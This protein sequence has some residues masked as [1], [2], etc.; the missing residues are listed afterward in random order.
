MTPFSWQ[1]KQCLF[2]GSWAT[3]RSILTI[4][5]SSCFFRT[6]A[7]SLSDILIYFYNS[8]FFLILNSSARSIKIFRSSA[9]NF[10]LL[11][12]ASNFLNSTEKT[13]FRVFSV[14]LFVVVWYSFLG[15]WLYLST[16]C[17]TIFFCVINFLLFF[18]RSLFRFIDRLRIDCS[19][20]KW[21][22]LQSTIINLRIKLL[23]FLSGCGWD[24]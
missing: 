13:L 8:V 19:Y 14:F 5:L 23:V 16:V 11:C 3:S 7:I 17:I 6:A 9:F 4:L 15:T 1:S 18:L 24:S 10:F 20:L 2:P 22:L 12:L 21:I